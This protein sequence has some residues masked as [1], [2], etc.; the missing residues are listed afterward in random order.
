MYFVYLLCVEEKQGCFFFLFLD[1]IWKNNMFWIVL[2]DS[3]Y[4]R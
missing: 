3:D 4:F 1:V 2:T